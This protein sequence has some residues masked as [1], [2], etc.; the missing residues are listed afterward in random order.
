MLQQQVGNGNSDDVAAA[1]DDGVLA[2]GGGGDDRDGGGGDGDGDVDLTYPKLQCHYGA[3]SR[4]SPIGYPRIKSKPNDC[5]APSR[6]TF[7]VQ[8]S[9]WGVRSFMH[10]KPMLVGL[11]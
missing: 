5:S 11:K 1:N 9:K 10:S 8:G 7:G 3:G 6:G 4:C 2:C